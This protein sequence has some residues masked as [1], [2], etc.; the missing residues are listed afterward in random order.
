MFNFH[1]NSGNTPYYNWQQTFLFEYLLF[2]SVPQK[3]LGYIPLLDISVSMSFCYRNFSRAKQFALIL[4]SFPVFNSWSNNFFCQISISLLL[5]ASC[6]ALKQCLLNQFP[7]LL[8]SLFQIWTKPNI[9]LEKPYLMASEKWRP[10]DVQ[11]SIN[12]SW[13]V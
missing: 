3:S 9:I 11:G 2:L 1:W 10:Q 12:I 13:A 8:I 5:Y 7:S 4:F 6:H